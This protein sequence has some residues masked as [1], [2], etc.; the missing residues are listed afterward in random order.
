MRQLFDG[1]L[2]GPCYGSPRAIRGAHATGAHEAIVNN[3]KELSGVDKAKVVRIAGS[4][5]NKK[6]IDIVF[7]AKK[8]GLHVLN[9]RVMIKPKKKEMKA[10]KSPEQKEGAKQKETKA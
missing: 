9:P 5:G 10:E 3:V 4:V 1:I 8:L 7:A 2:P 6:R